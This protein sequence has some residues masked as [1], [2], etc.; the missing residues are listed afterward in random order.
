MIKRIALLLALVTAVWFHGNHHG[1]NTERL[2]WREETDLAVA[3]ARDEERALQEKTNAILKKQFDDLASVHGRLITDLDQLRDR[4]KRSEVPSHSGPGCQGATGAGL[5]REDAR[6]LTGEAARANECRAALK[7]CY[8]YADS[9][10]TN[11]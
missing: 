2:Q 10:Q 11:Q 9:L 8:A 7:T 6:F 4:P 1:K 5:S 3:L